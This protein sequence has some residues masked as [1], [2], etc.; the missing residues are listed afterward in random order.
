MN[1]SRILSAPIHGLYA[2]TP[3]ETDSARLLA[4]VQ[5]AI[6]G[7]AKVIQYRNKRTDQSL[8]IEQSR[9]LL[10]LCRRHQ[11]PLIINDDPEL[12]RDIGADGVH[13]GA[14]DG[15]L[16]DARALLGSHAII[17][18]SCYNDMSLARLAQEQGADYV[19]FGA[20]FP[21][22]TKPH[23]VRAGLDLFSQG[24]RLLEVP[25]VAIGGITLQNAS[26]V[27]EAGAHSIAVISDL[28]DA[29]D[30]SQTAKQYANLFTTN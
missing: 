26:S 14:N 29:E 10:T 20:C 17:G 25:M 11:I 30:V 18:A 2:I 21:S 15:A 8:R 1:S 4:L 12:C 23:A 27:I 7:G 28:F 13:I 22:V 24:R 6:S 19:A 5:A 16:G 3:D 9:L